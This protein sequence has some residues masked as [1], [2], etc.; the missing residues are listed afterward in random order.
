M[1]KK[2]SIALVLIMAGALI[3]SACAPK[4]AEAAKGIP[5]FG[6]LGTADKALVDLKC[7]EVTIAEEDAYL[8]FNYIDSKTTKAGGWDYEVLPEICTRLHCKPVFT[9]VSWDAMI[10]SV[11]DGLYDVA[12]DG[13]TINDERKQIV[14]FSMGYLNIQQRLLARKGETRFTSIEDFVANPALIMGTQSATTNMETALK[15]LPESRVKGFEQFPFAIQALIGNDIDAVILDE[16]IGLGYV[17]TS[18][19]K[20]ELVGPSIESNQLGFVF[21]KGSTLVEPFNKA[22]Q[23]MID[24]GFL[25]K[26]NLKYFGPDFKVTYGDIKEIT[27]P[28][29]NPTQSK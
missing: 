14:D 27:Y 1:F 28:T 23:S 24:D 15:F 22:I 6:C 13:I 26:V 9:E 29:P 11:S 7:R 20:V 8:P 12:A 2:L 16:V 19:D 3:L 17:G 18:A 25:N 21:P 4:N 10:Q 5:Q